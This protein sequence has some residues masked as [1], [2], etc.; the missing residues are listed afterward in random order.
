M[1]TTKNNQPWLTILYPWIIW[2]IGASFFFYKYLVQVS[3]SVMTTDLMKAFHIHGAGLGNL[4]AFY[5]YAYLM[6]QIP[7]GILLDKYSPRFLTSIAI[8]VCAISTLIFSQTNSLWLACIAR[9][10]MG[11]GAAFAAVSC[12][13]LAT[14]WFPPKRFALV[15]GLCMTVAMLGAISG[16]APLSLL[17]Q[18]FDWR[19]A[20]EIISFLGIIL[21]LLYFLIVE[22]KSE[23]NSSQNNYKLFPQ[24]IFIIKNKQAWLLSIYS[25][26][27]FAPVSVFGGLWG[28]PYLETVH[29]LTPT[30]AAFAISW[31]FIGFAIGAPIFGWLSDFI[32]QRKPLLFLGTFIAL[33]C[34]LPTLYISNQNLLTLSLFLFFFGFG[35]SGFFASFAMIREIFPIILAATVLG[36]MNTFQS[37]CEALSEPLVGAFLDLTWHG[38]IING[39]HQF[40]INSYHLALL[41]L[42][43]YLIIALATLFFIEETYCRPKM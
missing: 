1:N 40:S 6:M 41:V 27:A 33:I 39:V 23:K 43:I 17:V 30:Q 29:Q 12:F 20:L 31:I 24:L 36:F 32:G 7:V 14:V 11:A 35:A 5:F 25:G 28:V 34:L 26:L 15:S 16:Q 18:T 10:F 9:A 42:P 4:S 22:D 2:A 38:K 19:M 3:P 37:I 21:G 8:L 13:K